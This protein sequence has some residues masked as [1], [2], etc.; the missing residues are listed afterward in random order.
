MKAI[1]RKITISRL[2]RQRRTIVSD[3]MQPQ[4]WQE[5]NQ[6]GEFRSVETK[7]AGVTHRRRKYSTNLDRYLGMWLADKEK[8]VA[9][10]NRRGITPDQHNVGEEFAEDY[11]VAVSVLAARGVD[12]EGSGG[13]GKGYWEYPAGAHEG[14]SKAFLAMTGGMSGKIGAAV[15]ERVCGHDETL[16]SIEALNGWPNGHAMIRLREGL[17]DILPYYQG[18]RR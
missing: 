11:N 16:G 17:N 6:P 2:E 9:H 10:E 3:A 15:V 1:H 8:G 14:V 7:V 13:G 18:R 4:D 12:L 5:Q